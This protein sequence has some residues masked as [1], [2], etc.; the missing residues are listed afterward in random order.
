[1]H[2]TVLGSGTSHPHP[3]RSSTSFWLETAAG[4]VLLDCSAAAIHRMAQERLPWAELDA[5]W[6]SHF[7]LDHIG[8]LAPFLFGM[9]HAAETEERRKPLTICGHL[10][11]KALFDAVDTAGNYRLLEQNFPVDIVEVSEGDAFTLIDGV[12]ARVYKTPH[13]PESLAIRLDDGENVLVFTSDTGFDP[14]IGEFAA[15]SDLFVIESS[16]VA[17][18]V[19]D[20]HLELSEAMELTSIAR[21]KRA[22]L[23]HLYPEWDDVKFEDLARGFSPPCEVLLAFDGMTIEI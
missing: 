3:T 16:F 23:N 10:G 11:L 18:K 1:M 15:D 8:G 22:L 20:T 21:P 9:K 12:A 14:K 4:S 13:K 5:I 19:V 2:L 6:I 7:H 17:N